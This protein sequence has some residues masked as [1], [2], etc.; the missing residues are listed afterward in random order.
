NGVKRVVFAVNEYNG[1]TKV[2]TVGWLTGIAVDATY[3][4]PTL[5]TTNRTNKF[6][7]ADNAKFDAEKK[8]YAFSTT[9]GAQFGVESISNS[10]LELQEQMKQIEI[11][12][13][14]KAAASTIKGTAKTIKTKK[15]VTAKKYTAKVKAVTSESGA[16]ATF[17]KANTAGKSKITV[18][19]SGKITIKKGLKKGTYKVK[20]KGTVGASSKTVTAKI[21]I[22]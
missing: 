13:Q 5:D 11:A 19:K 10:I 7:G 6:V 1:S 3:T 20:V 9:S 12:A 15:G 8:A 2:K 22:K 4:D 21:V 14:D 17:K 18:A 16:V